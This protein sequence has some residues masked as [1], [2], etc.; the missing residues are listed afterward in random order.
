MVMISI[1][2]IHSALIKGA[3]NDL[4]FVDVQ[5]ECFHKLLFFKNIRCFQNKA[6]VQ[7]CC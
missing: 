3:Q 2:C 5:N 6:L 7:S 4:T 1:H